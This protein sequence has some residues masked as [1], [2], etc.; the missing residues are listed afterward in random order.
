M[1]IHSASDPRRRVTVCGLTK[2][3]EHKFRVAAV[4]QAGKGPLVT[5]QIIKVNEPSKYKSFPSV[6]QYRLQCT[7]HVDV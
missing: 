4:N 5:S 7:K 1:Q 3:L 2:G 6:L